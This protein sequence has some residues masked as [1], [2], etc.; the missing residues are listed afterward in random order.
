MTH[1]QLESWQTLIQVKCKHTQRERKRNT[2][3]L[4]VRGCACVCLFGF[5]ITF[6]TNVIP[7]WDRER[8]FSRCVSLIDKLLFW[9][10]VPLSLSVLTKISNIFLI[11]RMF[12]GND[13][14]IICEWRR[15]RPDTSTKNIYKHF[16]QRLFYE[17]PIFGKWSK[18]LI[19]KWHTLTCAKC[20]RARAR[21]DATWLGDIHNASVQSLGM[22]NFNRISW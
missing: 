16:N 13:N 9:Q 17:K 3:S 8:I 4:C 10:V 15:K 6:Y 21:E 18:Q 22:E 7:T 5:T 1:K 19:A 14:V 2:A 20:G 11:I 12:H